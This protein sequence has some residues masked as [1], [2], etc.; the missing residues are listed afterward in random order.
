MDD[1]SSAQKGTVAWISHLGAR[2]PR[3]SGF[4]T[5]RGFPGNAPAEGLTQFLRANVPAAIG[6]VAPHS[7][8][9][10]R[11]MHSFCK[12]LASDAERVWF[13]SFAAFF[14]RRPGSGR[15]LYNALA[16]GTLHFLLANFTPL[17]TP[18][19]ASLPFPENAHVFLSV[20]CLLL[21]VISMLAEPQTYGLLGTGQMLGWSPKFA[22]PP[23]NH[24]DAITWMGVS[25]WRGGK[26]LL[27]ERFLLARYVDL[28]MK[29]KHGDIMG[30]IAFVLF[31]GVSIL[32]K[33]LTFGDCLTRGVAAFY[34]RRRSKSF[35]DW[36][37]SVEGAHLATWGI[38]ACL[39]LAAFRA[40]AEY[41]V[42]TK[43]DGKMSPAAAAA[44]AAA[45]AALLRFAERRSE[46][47]KKHETLFKDDAVSLQ[48]ARKTEQP[49]ESLR[50]SDEGHDQPCASVVEVSF[51]DIEPEGTKK[52]RRSARVSSRAA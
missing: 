20:S 40:A 31:T 21:A 12:R 30:A 5:A 44:C 8:L 9:P 13:G 18:V 11:R 17:T 43:S 32:P 42:S 50:A 39:L 25:A 34:L 47:T 48:S 16:A 10:P 52:T 36:V 45:T 33:E 26:H 35:R 1:A 15:L 27:G 46:K 24:M 49:R 37:A 2:A 28:K 14:L 41:D 19:V 29:A 23:P 4:L 22:T 38:R 3:L 6:F 7:L 51:R